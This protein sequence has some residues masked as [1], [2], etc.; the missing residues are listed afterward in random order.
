MATA[1]SAVVCGGI[2]H[3]YLTTPPRVNNRQR[4]QPV[5][6]PSAPLSGWGRIPLGPRVRAVGHRRSLQCRASSAGNEEQKP[7]EDITDWQVQNEDR[8]DLTRT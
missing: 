8:Y 5:P 7:P 2:H 3:L 1:M 6:R 4:L